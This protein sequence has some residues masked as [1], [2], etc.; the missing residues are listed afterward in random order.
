MPFVFMSFLAPPNQ[1]EHRIVVSP[2]LEWRPLV[3]GAG[4]WRH[5]THWPNLVNAR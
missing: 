3:S 4:G 2:R 5:R 1:C